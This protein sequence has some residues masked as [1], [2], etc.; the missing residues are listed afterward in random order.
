[1]L[2][3]PE[4]AKNAPMQ[5]ADGLEEREKEKKRACLSTCAFRGSK[6]I[7]TLKPLS[8]SLSLTWAELAA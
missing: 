5:S 3:K 6:G 7:E 2:R 4:S 1:M 8:L